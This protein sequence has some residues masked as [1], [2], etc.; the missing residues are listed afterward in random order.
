[1]QSA[2]ITGSGGE[3]DGLPSLSVSGNSLD[4]VQ[5]RFSSYPMV[6]SY[7]QAVKGIGFQRFELENVEAFSVMSC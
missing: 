2:V 1:M 6:K 7:D 5:L 4:R 3:K